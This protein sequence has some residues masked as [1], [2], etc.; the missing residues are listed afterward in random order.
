MIHMTGPIHFR[1]RNFSC[2]EESW[3]KIALCSQ[4]PH[5]Q[6]T[7]PNLLSKTFRYTNYF[8][9]FKGKIISLTCVHDIKTHIPI[10][11]FLCI[12]QNELNKLEE[13]KQNLQS[14]IT[15]CFRLGKLEMF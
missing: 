2:F 11:N 8:L 13:K 5:P 14:H 12:G 10:L 9:E 3:T 7:D 1:G 6:L 15:F 4:T